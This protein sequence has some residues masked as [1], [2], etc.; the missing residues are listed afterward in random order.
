MRLAPIASIV[1]ALSLVFA[2]C[3]AHAAD[4]ETPEPATPTIWPAHVAGAVGILGLGTALAF[5]SLQ[6]NAQHSQRVAQAT[7]MQAGANPGACRGE[8]IRPDLDQMCSL[9]AR[10][11]NAA[12][13]HQDA[14]TV[15]LSV[16]L[17]SL[18]FAVTWYLL[19]R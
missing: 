5:G 3:A 12:E 19:A 16:G 6:I 2:P 4:K 17:T 8:S 18:A 9:L 10:H 13:L 15:A 11:E 1:L 7:L 14:F